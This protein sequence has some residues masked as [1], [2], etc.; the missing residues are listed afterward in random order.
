MGSEP[1]VRDAWCLLLALLLEADPVRC[2]LGTSAGQ[3]CLLGPWMDP[4]Y[5]APK[6]D[7]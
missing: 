6:R 4:G 3:H 1:A 5:K 2:A 7:L